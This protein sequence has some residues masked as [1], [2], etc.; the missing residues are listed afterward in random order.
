MKLN[1]QVNKVTEIKYH[2]PL[3][4]TRFTCFFPFITGHAVREY[5]KHIAKHLIAFRPSVGPFI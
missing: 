2:F 5:L 3:K 1:R 4:A